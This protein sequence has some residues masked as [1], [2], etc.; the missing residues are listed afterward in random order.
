M[1][2]LNALRGLMRAVLIEIL[3]DEGEE[4]GVNEYTAKAYD[5]NGRHVMSAKINFY[6]FDQ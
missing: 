1:P 4:N 5:S 2:D 6:I 3:R